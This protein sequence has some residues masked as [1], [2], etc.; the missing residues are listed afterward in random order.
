MQREM[1]NGL[2]IC[3]TTPAFPQTS[4]H[5]PETTQHLPDQPENLDCRRC[6]RR[7]CVSL[8][9]HA[10]STSPLSVLNIPVTSQKDQNV[11]AAE[12]Y[13]WYP[14]RTVSRLTRYSK[15]CGEIHA[16][17]VSIVILGIIK[18][19]ILFQLLSQKGTS[20]P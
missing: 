11:R 7:I 14:Q 20:F 3:G 1:F 9:S 8:R 10:T 17:K 13:P 16:Q 5:L 12:L 2:Q 19:F 4:G 6:S 15:V 18:D